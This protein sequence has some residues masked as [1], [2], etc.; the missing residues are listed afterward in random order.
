[1]IYFTEDAG[2]VLCWY[3]DKARCMKADTSHDLEY[4]E[5]RKLIHS[6]APLLSPTQ[7]SGL[8]GSVDDRPQEGHHLFHSEEEGEEAYGKTTAASSR[9]EAVP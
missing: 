9:V 5:T 6:S 8:P 3:E 2:V 7:Q 4:N 1:M